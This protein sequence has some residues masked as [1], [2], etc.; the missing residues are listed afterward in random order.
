MTRLSMIAAIRD[1]FQRGENLMELMRQQGGGND[2]QSIMI[3]YDFQAGSY[4]ELAQERR[5]YFDAYTG[6]IARVFDGLG[7]WQSV[8]EVG[9]GEATVMAPLLQ[10][11]DPTAE[12]AAFG[13]DISWSRSRFARQNLEAVGRTDS[14]FVANLF[15]IPLPDNAIDIVYTSHSLEPNGGR[16]ADAIRELCRVARTYVVLLEPDYDAAP[17]EGKRRMTQHGY[18][19]DLGHHATQLGYDVSEERPFDIC[20]NPLNPTGL[21][22][23]RVGAQ[24]SSDPDYVCPITRTPL[25]RD[26]DVLFGD[27]SGL[28]YPI[29]DGL[30]CLLESSA[31]LGLHYGAFNGA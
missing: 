7:P 6:A 9:V 10:K 31:T 20:I 21:T 4:T 28:I 26:R 16:E 15:E 23:I 27:E 17:E 22:V 25:K 14:I 29:I 30:P 18:V 1:A 2:L 3:S 5:A 19:R 12:R 13:F 8:M 24:A 11:I